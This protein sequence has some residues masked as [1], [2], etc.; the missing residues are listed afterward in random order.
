MTPIS[1]LTTPPAVTAACHE[2][3]FDLPPTRQA[4]EPPEARGLARDEVRM[5]VAWRT[6]PDIEH[7]VFRHLPSYLEPGDLL[8]V[9]TSRTRPAAVAATAA[10]GR[11][12]DL[13][14]STRQEAGCWVVELRQPAPPA[15]LPYRYGTV[16]AVLK[17][18]AG[19]QA[20]LLAPYGT[21]GR[22]WLA[23]ITLPTS[24]ESW[25]AVHG[26]PIR[27][28][29]VPQH[30]PLARYQTVFADQDGSAEMPSAGRPFSAEVV[31]ALV[32]RGIAMAPL[33]L[34]TGVSSPEAH[35][36]PY[37]E[38]FRVPTPTASLVNHIRMRGGRVI[39]VGTTVVRALETVTDERGTVY[40]G[41]GWTDTVISP[42]RGVRAV[43]GMITGWHEPAASHL[44]M[45]EAV[46]GREL[47]VRS[48]NEALAAGYRWHEFGD[49]HLVLP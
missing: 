40:P 1:A 42:E 6:R 49:S 35:E 22:L 39:A 37:P 48:Y 19:G 8:V 17:L 16:G 33:V 41:E 43:D 45:L 26:R 36:L 18:A 32:R 14:F 2:L 5:L 28:Q 15:S 44:D 25:L 13:H 24:F 9:N 4:S 23:A 10:D 30:W 11:R 38:W 21:P 20:E 7:A 3:D 47:L 46:A 27:Y 31:A 29:H 12:L 34:H